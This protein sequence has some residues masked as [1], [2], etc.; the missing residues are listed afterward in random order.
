MLR[1]LWLPSHSCLPFN[2]N[3][4]FFF[5]PKVAFGLTNKKVI[6]NNGLVPVMIYLSLGLRPKADAEAFFAQATLL[7]HFF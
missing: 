1:S 5:L 3:I 7:L 2:A 4:H 6:N